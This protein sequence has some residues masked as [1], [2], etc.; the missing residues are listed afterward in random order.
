MT[1]LEKFIEVMNDTFNSGFTK[2]NMK[3]KCSPCGVLKNELAACV[4]LDCKECRAWWT[5]E[6]KPSRNIKGKLI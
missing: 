5:E 3:L 4:N 6:Y 1:N 2:D